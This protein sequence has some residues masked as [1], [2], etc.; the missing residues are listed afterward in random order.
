MTTQNNK[1]IITVLGTRPEIIRLS[2]V[3][4]F[5]DKTCRHL[6]VNTGQNFDKELNDNFFTDLKI[7][8]PSYSLNIKNNRSSIFFISQMLNFIEKI[9]KKEKP[10]AMVILG[11]T[12]SCLSAYVAKRYKVPIFHIEAGNRSF[13]QRVPEEINRKLVDHI[14][15][16][17]ITYSNYARENL[18]K[19][20]FPSD[21]V[22]KIGSP[23]FEVY[24][25]H[26]SKINNSKILKKLS[27]NKNKYYLCSIH[28]EENIDDKIQFQKV[29]EFLKKVSQHSKL[30]IIFSTHPRTKKK[31]MQTNLYNNN[32]ILF[33]KP[34]KYTDYMNL[35]INSKLVIS[36]S[37]SITEEASICN[38]KAINL[39][40]T[41]ERQEG[42]FKGVSSLNN[43]NYDYFKILEKIYE[44]SDNQFGKISEYEEKN[45]SKIFVNLLFSYIDNI[46]FY[47]W[48]N[49][50]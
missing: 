8:S 19:E 6:L 42:M 17:N 1:K 40:Q 15:D 23:L 21:K 26:K 2:S 20:N 44:K 14:S 10:N 32:K 34:F 7:K 36:D 3:I 13:D 50:N 29:C 41:F 33:A 30:K 46:N 37:G 25:A 12:N 31:L 49:S 4:S 22:F 9:L 5:L 24:H 11:D 47:T 45:F 28:R 18:L 16:I 35:Q 43:F 27:L 48:K 39:R 38:F